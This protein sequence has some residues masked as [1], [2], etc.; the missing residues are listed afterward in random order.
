MTAMTRRMGRRPAADSVEDRTSFAEVYRRHHA[1][2]VRLAFLLCGDAE[3]AADVVADAWVGVYRRL[4]RGGIED[5]GPYLR[6]A[7]VNANRSRARH[8]T[9]ARG[10]EFLDTGRFRDIPDAG[11]AVATRAVMLDALAELPMRMRLAVVLRYYEDRSVQETAAL[12]HVSPG[13]VKSTTSKALRRL[14]D[15]LE[16]P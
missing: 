6:R 9:L 10:L 1:P 2:A 13:T 3:I 7:V 14:Q 8:E 12:M 15:L 16:Q 5:V 4:G 11:E